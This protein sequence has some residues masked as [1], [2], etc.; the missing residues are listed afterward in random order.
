MI[1]L[2]MIK[3]ENV[4]YSLMNAMSFCLGIFSLKS[5]IY[6]KGNGEL[7]HTICKIIF[8]AILLH[9]ILLRVFLFN[10]GFFDLGF[11]CCTWIE[12][13]KLPSEL[14]KEARGIWVSPLILGEKYWGRFL[15]TYINH[16][17]NQKSYNRMCMC[18]DVLLR[19]LD[20]YTAKWNDQ[21]G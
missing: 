1:K 20:G 6:K 12:E 8:S 15:P 16:Q 3:I 13:M 14:N 9:Q 4:W 11:F 19:F 7:L 2:L 17:P 18:T 5:F 10:K 21:K